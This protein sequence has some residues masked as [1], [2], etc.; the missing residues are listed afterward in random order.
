MGRK[1]LG[2]GFLIVAAELAVVLV[3]ILVWIPKRL[4]TLAARPDDS[5]ARLEK[6][7]TALE[8]RLSEVVFAIEK[9]RTDGEESRVTKADIARLSNNLDDIATEIYDFQK[10][11]ERSFMT[12][13]RNILRRIGKGEAHSAGAYPMDSPSALAEALEKDGVILEKDKGCCRV[14]AVASNPNRPLELVAGIEGGNLYESLL[15]LF[16]KPSALRA[17]LLALGARPGAPA[18]PEKRLG[19]TG[20]RLWL[21]LRWK[22]LEKPIP[23]EEF[24]LNA[25]TG[26]PMKDPKWVFSGSSF[27]SNFRTGEEYYVP[28]ES[29]VVIALTWNF[30]Y[31]SVIACDHE[32]AGNEFLWAVN[33]DKLPEDPATPM[34]LLVCTHPLP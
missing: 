10:S 20:S 1:A 13:Q 17:A 24:I 12:V 7:M 33:R 8:N 3:A 22:G 11:V 16:A 28:D 15:E 19:P 27:E 18:Q 23:L 9:S 2:I 32:D 31:Q 26:K 29:R 21:Y 5:T 6:R 34:E 30:T 4:D 14:K 25:Q